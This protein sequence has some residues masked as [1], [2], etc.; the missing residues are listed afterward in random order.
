[1]ELYADLATMPEGSGLNHE[2]QQIDDFG[3]LTGRV[4]QICVAGDLSCSAPVNAAL[5]RA[6]VAIMEH[7]GTDFSSDPLAAASAVSQSLTHTAATG[8]ATSL[9]EDWEGDTIGAL[10]PTGEFSV[11]ERI[12]QAATPE[13]VQTRRSTALRTEPSRHLWPLSI[14]RGPSASMP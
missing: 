4:A 1:M 5:G 6:A 2:A 9:S 3:T 12:E 14:G 10:T 13:S 7:A 11:S 8:V